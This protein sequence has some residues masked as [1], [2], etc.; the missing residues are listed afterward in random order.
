M[1]RSVVTD[2]V[3]NHCGI[4][5]ASKPIRFRF[6]GHSLEE[7]RRRSLQGQFSHRIELLQTALIYS[8]VQQ[9]AQFVRISRGER[10]HNSKLSAHAW[11]RQA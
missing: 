7:P 9:R 5:L 6:R 3:F 11:R 10:A 2:R 1:P 8:F 4:R